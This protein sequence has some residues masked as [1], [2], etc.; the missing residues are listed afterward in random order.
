[1][2]GPAIAG[3]GAPDT[4]SVAASEFEKIMA[5]LNSLGS[6]MDIHGQALALQHQ[7]LVQHDHLLRHLNQ[8]AGRPSPTLPS[9]HDPP[10]TGGQPHLA[11]PPVLPR[12][13]A[14]PHHAEPR[15]P[16]PQRYNGNPGECRGFLTQCQLTFELQPTSFPT[17]RSRIA[18]I[19]TLL[20]DKALAWATA[21]W[22]LQG[23]E[24]SNIILFIKD[25][26][27]IFDQSASG[28]EAAKNLLLLRQGKDRVSD[29]AISFRTLAAESGWN[30]TALITTFVSGLSDSLKYFLAATECPN[31]LESIISQ[32]VRL[33]NR[34]QERRWEQASG[35]R[36]SFQSRPTPTTLLWNQPTP[37]ETTEPLQ[38]GRAH[39]SPEEK[40]R[41]RREKLCI[42]CG[43]SGHFRTFCPDL[44][45]KDQPRP[46]EG[47]L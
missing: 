36:P 4:A 39:L 23:P 41:R 13:V 8:A 42:Y 2:Y 6:T 5:A 43:K 47:G 30:E 35:Q 16:T 12:P 38:I 14:P 20:T 46:A 21:I 32:A 18:Y 27:R 3:A 29:Y 26:L 11:D 25:M 45:G 10:D 17:A 19:I 9:G 1:M 34:L 44:L 7:T 15:L 28:Q 22:Q 24:C 33:D 31:D 37:T 40:D